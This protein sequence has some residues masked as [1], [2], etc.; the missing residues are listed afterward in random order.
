MVQA[1]D[2]ADWH[3]LAELGW[4][5]RPPVRRIFGEGKVGSGAAVIREVASQD[6]TQV[7]LAEDNDVVETFAPN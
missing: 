4:F 7:A 5:D 6:V 1:P 2:F 3:N